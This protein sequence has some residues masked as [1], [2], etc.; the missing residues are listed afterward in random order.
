MKKA[1]LKVLWLYL[2]LVVC[3]GGGNEPV[4][5]VVPETP[6]VSHKIE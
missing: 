1:T 3:S 2:L 5:P 6:V 4:Q